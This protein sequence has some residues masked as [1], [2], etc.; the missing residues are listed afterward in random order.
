MEK[1]GPV[2]F[3]NNPQHF[4]YPNLLDAH[5]SEVNVHDLRDSMDVQSARAN[6]ALAPKGPPVSEEFFLLILFTGLG[7]EVPYITWVTTFLGACLDIVTLLPKL[8]YLGVKKL[9]K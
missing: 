6:E 5:V 9:T 7:S 4:E 1:L 2:P 8:A 3:I